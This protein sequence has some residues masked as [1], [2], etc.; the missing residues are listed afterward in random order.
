MEATGSKNNVCEAKVV[1]LNNPQCT[2]ATWNVGHMGST[3]LNV[4]WST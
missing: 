1:Y 4:H 2:L 3:M